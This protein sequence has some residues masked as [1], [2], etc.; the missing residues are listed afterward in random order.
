MNAHTTSNLCHSMCRAPIR[1]TSRNVADD[2]D[3]DHGRHRNAMFLQVNQQQTKELH[4]H[5]DEENIAHDQ[6]KIGPLDQQSEP[7]A[8]SLIPIADKQHRAQAKHD[9]VLGQLQILARSRMGLAHIDGR[10]DGFGLVSVHSISG[11][12]LDLLGSAST[13]RSRARLWPTS[14]RGFTLRLFPAVAAIADLG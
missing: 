5:E 12:H 1:M 2:P 6:R 14:R 9:D 3:L 11:A 8:Q 10:S 13:V 7:G 4:Q